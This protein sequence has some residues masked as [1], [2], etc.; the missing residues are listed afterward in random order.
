MKK[1]QRQAMAIDNRHDFHAFPTL[2]RAYLRA[3]S[4]RHHKCRI[5]EA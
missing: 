2:G 3:T 4:L 5:E 1:S